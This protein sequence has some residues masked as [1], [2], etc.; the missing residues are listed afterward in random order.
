ML[1][2][3][4]ENEMD[5][6]REELWP[7]F[8]DT[9]VLAACAPGCQSMTLETPYEITAILA[10]GVGSVKP[11]FEVDAVVTQLEYPE[12]LEVTATGQSPRNEF[13]MTATMEMIERNSGGTRVEWEANADVSGTIVSLGG[14]ALKSVT[15]RLVKQY[16]DDMQATVEAGEGAE[17]KLEEAPP[18]ATTDEEM[19]SD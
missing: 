12:L 11:E 1:E 10:V 16:F 13:E 6:T 14:R 2:F 19:E 9:D 7:Y 15:N 4:G 5:Q 3:S 18:G 17:S 8:T